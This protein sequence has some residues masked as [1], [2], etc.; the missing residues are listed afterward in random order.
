MIRVLVLQGPNLN[1]LGTREPEIYG[2]ET[3]DEI[4]EEPQHSRQR[5]GQSRHRQEQ[6]RSED[7]RD[8]AEGS[9]HGEDPHGGGGEH[10]TDEQ[11]GHPATHGSL[12]GTFADRPYGRRREGGGGVLGGEA[13]VIAEEQSEPAMAHAHLDAEPARLEPLVHGRVTAAG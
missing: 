4:H 9:R 8:H 5:R 13:A 12:P 1:L 11:D 6:G 2:Y 10:T 3:L 7:G